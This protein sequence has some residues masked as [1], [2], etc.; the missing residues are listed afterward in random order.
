MSNLKNKWQTILTAA[1]ANNFNPA[2]LI[3][4]TASSGEWHDQKEKAG[5]HECEIDGNGELSCR[6][7]ITN[8]KRWHLA[9]VPILVGLSKK[10]S[11]ASLSKKAFD[12]VAELVAQAPDGANIPIKV[13]TLRDKKGVLRGNV[14]LTEDEA[15]MHNKVVVNNEKWF[16]PATQTAAPV[17]PTFPNVGG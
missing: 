15:I 11:T 10:P 14:Y 1:I 2:E 3:D 7:D 16:A 9:S 12:K 13:V 5:L 17:A 8:G 6:S 4:G